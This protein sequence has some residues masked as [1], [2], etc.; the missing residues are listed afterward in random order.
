M[1]DFN[2]KGQVRKKIVLSVAS[3]GIAALLLP[4]GKAV[5]SRFKISLN[6]HQTSCCYINHRT[7]LATLIYEAELII[8]DEAPMMSR[9]TFDAADRTFRDIV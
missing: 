6:L 7:D 2:S 5:H 3:L 9:Y 8:W 4:N 1:E